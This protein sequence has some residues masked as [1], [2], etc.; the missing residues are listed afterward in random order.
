MQTPGRNVSFA[1]DTLAGVPYLVAHDFAGE[2]LVPVANRQE[3]V[4]GETEILPGESPGDLWVRRGWSYERF[5]AQTERLERPIIRPALTQDAETGA[6]R[7]TEGPVFSSTVLLELARVEH[8]GRLFGITFEDSGAQ[9]FYVKESTGIRARKVAECKDRLVPP[10]TKLELVEAQDGAPAAFIA[11]PRGASRGTIVFFHGG[12]WSDPLSRVR[13]ASFYADHGFKFILPVIAGGQMAPSPL[14]QTPQ[15]WKDR[16]TQA[17]ETAK[18]IIAQHLVPGRPLHIMGESYGWLYRQ[19]AGAPADL[20]T[21]F[22]LAPWIAAFDAENRNPEL[23][24]RMPRGQASWETALF[25][26]P[27]FAPQGEV[28]QWQERLLKTPCAASNCVIIKPSNE[29][30]VA[31]TEASYTDLSAAGFEVSTPPQT[32][33]F[34]ISDYEPGVWERLCVALAI[35]CAD[36]PTARRAARR[37]F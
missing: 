10:T 5:G 35:D 33:H 28:R 12:P 8:R 3:A 29:N 6:Y 4:P 32:F 19:C 13:S 23:G 30:R 18:Q 11:H 31:W 27:A 17:C 14:L 1:S 37:G 22:F 21:E 20:R 25:G 15:T 26:L 7:K 36:S 2:R 16:T 9:S 34:T 24:V